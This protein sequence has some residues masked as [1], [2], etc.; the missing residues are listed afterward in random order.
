[1]SVEHS[2]HVI[3]HVKFYRHDNATPLRLPVAPRSGRLT[4]ELRILN[5][6]I[7]RVASYLADC[8]YNKLSSTTAYTRSLMRK[9]DEEV[10]AYCY[11]NMRLY[12]AA[13][14]GIQMRAAQIT[15]DRD[16]LHKTLMSNIGN[17]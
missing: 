16:Q 14:V 7:E 4:I 17:G 1:M 10:G 13:W 3:G 15:H 9:A 12:K 5:A 11:G 8:N 6:L 2:D